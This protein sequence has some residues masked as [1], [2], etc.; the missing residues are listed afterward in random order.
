M[1]CYIASHKPCDDGSRTVYCNAESKS[2]TLLLCI[3]NTS[4]GVDVCPAAVTD[5]ISLW[6]SSWTPVLA[7][8]LSIRYFNDRAELDRLPPMFRDAYNCKHVSIRATTIGTAQEPLIWQGSIMADS[9]LYIYSKDIHVSIPS[10]VG[11]G[12]ILFTASQ[13]LDIRQ[14]IAWLIT[15]FILQCRQWAQVQSPASPLPTVCSVCS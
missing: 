7:N 3:R 6:S 13:E 12:R 4:T 9:E 14:V 1:D 5:V 8:L 15:A 2:L 11:W 10:D